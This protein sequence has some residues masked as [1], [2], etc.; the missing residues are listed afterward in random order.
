[1]KKKTVKILENI[2]VALTSIVKTPITIPPNTSVL[3]ARDIL[4]R[5][6]IGRL[7]IE[8]DKKPVGIITEKDIAKSVSI[9]SKK[10]IRKILVRDIMSKNL[11][12]VSLDAFSSVLHIHV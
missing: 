9:Y 12:S 1:M 11:V 8:F 3:D 4:I 5:H 2:P 7:V 6:R 10:P